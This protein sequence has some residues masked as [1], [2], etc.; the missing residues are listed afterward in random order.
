M[1]KDEESTTEEC[2]SLQW[3]ADLAM[4]ARDS[5]YA[6]QSGTASLRRL[7]YG[8]NNQ[9]EKEVEDGNDET[10]GGLFTVVK[11][12]G[13]VSKQELNSL[14]CTVWRVEHSQDWERDEVRDRIKDCFVTGQWA[15]GQDVEELIKLEEEEEELP[16]MV[17]LK[18]ERDAE[19]AK[20][21]ERMERKLKLKKSFDTEYDGG[22]GDKDP[23]KDRV[24]VVLD[25]KERKVQNAFKMLRE[26]YGQKQI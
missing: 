12:R 14:D 8:G 22:E 1:G 21:K 15:K 9:E 6:R 3:K 4:K 16:R 23:T 10:V 20:R 7:V 18:G 11:A 24:A 17:D 2:E 19:L 26:M 13:G 5:F 25:H